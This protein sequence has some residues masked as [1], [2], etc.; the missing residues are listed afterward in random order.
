MFDPYYRWLGIPEAEQPPTL[1]RLLGLSPLESNPDVIEE[2][3]D[4]Q[5]AHVRTHHSGPHAKESQKLLNELAAAKLT[6]LNAERKSEYD[7][8][9]A[10]SISPHQA[11]PIPAPTIHPIAIQRVNLPAQPVSFAPP[12]AAIEAPAMVRSVA[13]QRILEAERSKAAGYRL[14]ASVC[15]LISA[16]VPLCFWGYISW[17]EHQKQPARIESVA[18]VQTPAIETPAMKPDAAPQLHREPTAFPKRKSWNGHPKGMPSSMLP[19][20]EREDNLQPEPPPETQPNHVVELRAFDWSVDAWRLDITNKIELREVGSDYSIRCNV[21]TGY[22]YKV[23]VFGDEDPSKKKLAIRFTLTEGELS[24]DLRPSDLS[25][26]RAGLDFEFERDRPYSVEIWLDEN[27][28]SYAM[29]DGEPAEITSD[30]LCR[31]RFAMTV[32]QHCS[33]LIHELTFA[34]RD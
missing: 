3:A 29:V 10:G 13:A 31:E 11:T 14:L 18:L 25:K 4:R 16:C 19:P 33:M 23:L 20:V 12:A 5:M 34:D 8:S 6:L 1:Y 7:R 9:L 15:G 30:F 21:P 22:K 32:S 24:F 26:R 2:A 17:R 28:T 27:N